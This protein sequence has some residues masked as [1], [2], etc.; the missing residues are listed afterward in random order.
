MLSLITSTA[1]RIGLRLRSGCFGAPEEAAEAKKAFAWK[2]SPT[3][4][5]LAEGG[6]L[7]K[8][9]MKNAKALRD[10][11]KSKG[12]LRNGNQRCKGVD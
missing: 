1:L 2:K 12:G 9:G 8:S 10:V 6:V 11:E 7:K 5:G 4:P 3:F